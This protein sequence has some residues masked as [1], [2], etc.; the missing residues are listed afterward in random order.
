MARG[1]ERTTSSAARSVLD[2]LPV[3]P[4]ERKKVLVLV[5]LGAVCV[6][7]VIV[8]V[9]RKTGG[10][11]AAAATTAVAT[12]PE[13]VDLD[14][15]VRE[16][17]ATMYRP[18]SDATATF[19]T[20]SEA[21]GLLA[22]GGSAVTI[23]PEAMRLDAFG[24]PRLDEPA[25][26]GQVEAIAAPTEPEADPVAEAF[27]GL[28]LES[29]LIGSRSRAAIINGKVLG[30]GERIDGFTVDA[31]APGRVRLVRDGRVFTLKLKAYTL[32]VE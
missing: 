14:A 15:I 25:L 12:A 16:M 13:A 23:G 19:Q 20:V 17:Q 11:T 10:S 9:L 29:I 8:Q 28:E 26:P 30:E 6:L 32:T 4:A 27:A 24:L 2:R 22:G 5:A 3:D 1:A 18:A 21:V 31:I 7:V